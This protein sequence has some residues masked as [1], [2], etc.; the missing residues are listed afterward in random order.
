M[1]MFPFI[2]TIIVNVWE[3]QYIA[4]YVWLFSGV[5]YKVYIIERKGA[6]DEGLVS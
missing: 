5:L 4:F 2:P 1:I 6:L 3:I